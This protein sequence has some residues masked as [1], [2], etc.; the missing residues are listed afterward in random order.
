MKKTIKLVL[1]LVLFASY[2]LV[3]NDTYGPKGYTKSMKEH[4]IS[5]Q[6]AV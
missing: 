6:E 2:S 4:L 5:A 1:F 3:A